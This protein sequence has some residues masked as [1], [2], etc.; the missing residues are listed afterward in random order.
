MAEVTIDNFPI[1]QMK[2]FLG[3]MNCDAMIPILDEAI[4]QATQSAYKRGREEV[5]AEVREK[6]KSLPFISDGNVFNKN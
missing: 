1:A 6:V 2:S 4:L 3:A 5:L